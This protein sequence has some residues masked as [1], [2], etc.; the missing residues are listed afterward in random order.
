M[1]RASSNNGTATVSEG[2]G[3]Y[4]DGSLSSIAGVYD[5]IAYVPGNTGLAV[6]NPGGENEEWIAIT[7][8]T[9]V[10]GGIL[11]EGV[12]RCVGDSVVRQ[13]YE[14]EDFYFVDT[15]MYLQENARVDQTDGDYGYRSSIRPY[16]PSGIGVYGSETAEQSI[17]IDRTLV[18]YPPTNV[19]CTQLSP[20]WLRE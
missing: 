16:A 1:L 19:R 3:F 2:G 6:I 15:G 4:V 17:T 10:T 14:G 7:T 12:W 11:C 9:A 8:I 18:P 20:T 13:H 5:P